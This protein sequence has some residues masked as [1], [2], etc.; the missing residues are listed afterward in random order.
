MNV[1]AIVLAAGQ[2]ARFDAARSKL[3][4]D[5]G[6]RALVRCAAEAALA[7]HASRTI[8]ITGHA[9]SEVERALAGLPVAFAHNADYA[10]GMASSLRVGLAHAADSAGAL[11]LLADMPAVTSATLDLLIAAFERAPHSPAVAP[12]YRG[13]RGNPVL[14]GGGLFARLEEL[15]GDEGA[16]AVL[17]LIDGVAEIAVDDMGVISDIDTREDLER[18]RNSAFS[19]FT[20][21]GGNAA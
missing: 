8:V 13:R 7:S 3:L 20:G 18:A 17:R 21:E 12:T 5:F 10:S 19:R 15:R 4:S 2:G 1:V 14:L 11:V 6:G 16:R 9:R